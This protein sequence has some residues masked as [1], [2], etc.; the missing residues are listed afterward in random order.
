MR[1]DG[2]HIPGY[3]V[4]IVTLD[5]HA[6][7]PAARVSER[8]SGEFQDCQS[9]SCQRQWAEPRRLG[10]GAFV[11]H[12]DIIV[13]NLLF[14]EA[15]LAILPELQARRDACDAMIGMISAKKCHP[16]PH[17]RVGYAE[18]PPQARWKLFEKAAWFVKPSNANSGHKQM[19]MLRRLPKILRSFSKAQDLR[20]WFL[21]MQYWLGSSDDNVEQMIRFLVG[22]LPAN[23]SLAPEAEAPIDYPRTW[24]VSLICRKMGS[25]RSR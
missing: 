15:Y 22:L 5:S 13:A 14:I 3:R 2:D 4:V 12:G 18:A 7:G 8:L 24:T 10:R 16:H 25:R 17:G 19:T 21:T 9:P 20:A 23:R 6:T 1:G 11:R